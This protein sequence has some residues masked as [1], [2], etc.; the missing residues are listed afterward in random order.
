[1]SRCGLNF[2]IFWV[3]KNIERNISGRLDILASN[4]CRIWIYRACIV[5]NLF[6]SKTSIVKNLVYREYIFDKVLSSL[7]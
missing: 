5:V 3:L 1:M 2:Q 7:T 6:Y 4:Y